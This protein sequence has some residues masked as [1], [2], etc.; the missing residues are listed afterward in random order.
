MTSN[1][2]FIGSDY[3]SEQF[4]P[5]DL[6]ITNQVYTQTGKNHY[7]DEIEFILITQGHAHI[8]INGSLISVVRGD[9]VQ[10][11]PYHVHRFVLSHPE[12]LTTIR[13]RCSIG[14]LL[15]TSTN[16]TMYLKAIREL[17][18]S[19]PIIHLTTAAKDQVA[20]ICE[21]VIS[22]H[23]QFANTN[24]ESLNIALIAFL[25]YLIE[26]YHSHTRPIQLNIGWQC[27]QY[28]Q[29][30][31]Q[32]ISLSPARVAN[33]LGIH[34][35]QVRILIKGLTGYTFT[36]VLNQVRIRN[37]TALLQFDELSTNQISQI[38]GYQTQSNFYKQF[39]SIHGMTPKSYRKTM[40]NRFDRGVSLDAWSIVMIILE[41]CTKSFNLK[42]LASRSHFSQKTIESL[43][44]NNLDITFK[45]L[46]DQFRIQIAYSLLRT[47]NLS[48]QQVA[49]RVG[50]S[51]IN[52]FLR[53]F[54]KIYRITPSNVRL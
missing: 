36:Q 42:D 4:K 21:S 48:V 54:K 45:Q 44:K 38:C 10:L 12:K 2:P 6:T 49:F 7:R 28:I 41:N 50:F 37:A 11:M 17:D 15:M 34:E 9:L 3:F 31:H 22:E 33:T 13:I 27:L 26:K 20:H 29:I 19:L 39:E 43:L 5:T 40:T 30:H 1:F 46:R 23:Q 47:L 32:E 52:T 16:R 18:H 8:E 35:K 53:N 14:L 24:F 51:D 25:S